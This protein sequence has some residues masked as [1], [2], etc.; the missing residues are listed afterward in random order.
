MRAGSYTTS[1]P[2]AA[3]PSRPDRSNWSATRTLDDRCTPFDRS[4]ARLAGGARSRSEASVPSA[5]E[6]AMPMTQERGGSYP[7]LREVLGGEGF[8]EL[9]RLIRTTYEPN[10]ERSAPT[11]R[12][13]RRGP[14]GDPRP[15][16]QTLHEPRGI[17]AGVQGGDRQRDNA[18]PAARPRRPA[19]QPPPSR[20]GSL[21]PGRWTA[22][23]RSCDRRRA[24][25]IVPI[26]GRE[27]D[28]GPVERLAALHRGRA[29]GRRGRRWPRRAVGS[30]SSSRSTEIG[31]ESTRGTASRRGR[32]VDRPG[33]WA[34]CRTAA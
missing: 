29:R 25:W 32:R 3:R 14:R 21:N 28:R 10:E 1:Q 31:G 20:P 19:N 8:A 22:P 33:P 24:G 9:A 30:R 2:M 34:S 5:S 4:P 11:G 7:K 23:T 13:E 16:P 17:E 26:D 18:D 15:G 27:E 12:R 6:T